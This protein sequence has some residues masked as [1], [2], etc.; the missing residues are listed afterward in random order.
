MNLS[1]ASG[2]GG[3]G[4][5]SVALSLALSL[6]NVQILDCDV[7]E[8]NACIFLKPQIENKIDISVP[9]PEIDKE[10]CNFCGRCKELCVYN[11]LAVLSKTVLVFPELCHSCGV[12][13][14]FCPQNAIHETGK[15]IG[16]IEFGRKDKLKFVQGTLN[17]GQSMA[18]PLIREVKKYLD[19][20]RINIIDVPAGTSCPVVESVKG[21]DFCI[22]VTEPTPFGLNDLILAV[23]L[24]RIIKIPF[25]VIVNRCDIG[26]DMTIQ[27]C[28]QQNIPVLLSIPFKKEIASAYSEGVALVDAFREYKAEFIKV[29]T[30]IESILKK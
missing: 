18:P 21:S 12:C 5:T 2:K 22:L 15:L 7:E 20:D 28:R 30:N 9:I 23:D 1:V 29:Y 26:D 27:Y 17:I 19:S 8:P 14:H 3:T 11:A 13:V 10:K 25:G 6:D 24:L 4:K 16:S